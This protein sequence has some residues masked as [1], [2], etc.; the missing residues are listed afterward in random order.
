MPTFTASSE[1]LPSLPDFSLFLEAHST[2]AVPDGGPF[3][4]FATSTPAPTEPQGLTGRASH[5]ALRAWR[6]DS[7]RAS[8]EHYE[9]D[10]LVRDSQGLRPLSPHERLRILGFVSGHGEPI[11]K[12]VLKR[13]VADALRNLAA[14]SP[15]CPAIAALFVHV[16]GLRVTEGP[17]FVELWA[18]WQHLDALAR[19]RQGPRSWRDTFARGGLVDGAAEESLR[20]VL[21][22]SR[23]TSHRGSDVR[24]ATGTL[25][26]PMSAPFQSFDPGLWVWKVLQSYPWKEP[27][28]HITYLEVLAVFNTLRKLSRS[29]DCYSSRLL[30]L[31]DSQASL[32]ALCKGRSSSRH[33]NGT[34]RR[35]SSLLL[36]MNSH[37]LYGWIRSESNPADAPSRWQ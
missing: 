20:L 2:R 32:G 1:A 23:A 16:L 31:V 19:H 36:A 11:S 37:V 24:L 28:Q 30:H 34:L 14:T 6:G 15:L 8:P 18:R 3:L 35:L 4:P 9:L 25:L 13:D 29:A 21:H 22:T 27:G 10:W 26:R 7:F 17:F 33:L 12:T 5:K